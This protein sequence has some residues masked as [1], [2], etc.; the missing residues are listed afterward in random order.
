MTIIWLPNSFYNNLI[1]NPS[2]LSTSNTCKSFVLATITLEETKR[3]V[4]NV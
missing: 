4:E 3:I 2:L 1:W